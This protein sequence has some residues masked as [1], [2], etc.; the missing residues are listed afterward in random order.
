MQLPPVSCYILYLVIHENAH[1]LA[2][3]AAVVTKLYIKS[4][5]AHTHAGTVYSLHQEQ[6]KSIHSIIQEWQF[7]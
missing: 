1:S 6:D 7:Q 3:I 2:Q 5:C 4:V